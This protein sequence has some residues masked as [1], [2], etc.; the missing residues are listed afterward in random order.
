MDAVNPFYFLNSIEVTMDIFD[1]LNTLYI[2]GIYTFRL[3]P[4]I[5]LRP[6]FQ[7]LNDFLFSYTYA[8]MLLHTFFQW[9][10][11]PDSSF[12]NSEYLIIVIVMSL[13]LILKTSYESNIYD[14]YHRVINYLFG[15]HRQFGN[16]SILGLIHAETMCL[17]TPI[18]DSM[19]D[20]LMELSKDHKARSK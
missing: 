4:I 5:D 16:R 2:N 6:D 7:R 20:Y 14:K 11:R 10:T 8:D 12:D 17:R 19:I 18:L 1:R 3:P 13:C 9:Y 15:H